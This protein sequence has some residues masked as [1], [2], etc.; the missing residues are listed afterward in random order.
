VLIYLILSGWSTCIGRL[1]V[2]IIRPRLG[3]RFHVRRRGAEIAMK[4]PIVS[5]LLGIP[6]F[7]IAFF[8]GSIILGIVN[9]QQSSP[10][11]QRWSVLLILTAY[12]VTYFLFGFL[13]SGLSRGY[14]WKSGSGVWLAAVP[15]I[16][17]VIINFTTKMSSGDVFWETLRYTP[18][19]VLV[20]LASSCVGALLASWRR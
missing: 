12:S 7:F 4:H 9:N 8:I 1:K 6:A 3:S 14:G 15:T 10:V 2:V 18:I 19:A 5:A 13:V 20:P 17:I 16:Y 11:N